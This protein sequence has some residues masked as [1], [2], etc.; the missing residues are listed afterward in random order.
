[1]PEDI[2]GALS[3]VDTLKWEHTTKIIYHIA[4]SPCHGIKFNGLEA[5]NDDYPNGD[6][7]GIE[8]IQ[9]LKKLKQL[10]VNY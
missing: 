4:D 5:S 1:M 8:P 3:I 6:P 9:F 2:V 7:S 10:D